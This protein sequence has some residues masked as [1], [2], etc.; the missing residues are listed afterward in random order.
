MKSSTT[1]SLL[2]WWVSQKYITGVGGGFSFSFSS[3]MTQIIVLCQ[4]D[5]SIA[6]RFHTMREK[7]PQ[8][9]NS[10][11]VLLLVEQQTSSYTPTVSRNLQPSFNISRT[12]KQ[13]VFISIFLFAVADYWKL[14]KTECRCWQ[15][16]SVATSVA[17]WPLLH[18]KS[19]VCWNVLWK[20]NIISPWK[21]THCVW[22]QNEEQ[23]MVLWICHF[24]DNFCFLQETERKPN[25]RGEA[26]L[27]SHRRCKCAVCRWNCVN[28]SL[29]PDGVLMLRL[30]SDTCFFISAVVLHWISAACL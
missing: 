17:T 30:V 5:A 9:F 24:R 20:W 13:A 21:H 7:H 19:R 15:Q 16:M 23:A 6:H 10:R 2:A 22:P 12:S 27:L 8:K 1:T 18:L 26:Q 28:C 11:Y 14:K 3:G 25:N 29:R 4:Q